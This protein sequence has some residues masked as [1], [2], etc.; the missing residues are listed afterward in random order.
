MKRIIIRLIIF[1]LL[2]FLLDRA[3]GTIGA[4]FYS[5][6]QS[7]YTRHNYY[8]GHLMKEEI[9]ILGSSRA[10]RHYNPTIISDSTGSSCYNC[11][12]D[13]MGIIHD[14]GKLQMLKARYMPKM[15]VMDITASFT[16]E[17]NDNSKYITYLKL[18]Y[19][20]QP[21]KQIISDLFPTE[22]WKMFCQSYKYNS[23]WLKMVNDNIA[24]TPPIPANGYDPMYGVLPYDI[25]APY[26]P[27]KKIIIDSVKLKYLQQTIETFHTLTQLVFIISP[28]YKAPNSENY[29]ILK[30][31]CAE[32]DIPLLDFY[33]APISQEKGLWADVSHMNKNGAEKYSAIIA[34]KLKQIISDSEKHSRIHQ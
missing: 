27:E 13:G 6:A 5:H 19:T 2:C 33:A 16:L 14:F 28:Q 25:V 18:D 10:A 24:S 32:Y 8:I 22:R 1:I 26:I 20:Q 23:Q 7:G 31:L 9:I 4:Y 30:R 3:I 21:I 17:Q 34:G 15:I 12:I 11:G 29:S